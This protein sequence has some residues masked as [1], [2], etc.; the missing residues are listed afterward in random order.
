M[1]VVWCALDTKTG[2]DV[3]IKVMKDISD[4]ASLQLFTKGVESAC[5]TISPEHR[6]CS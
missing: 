1:G 5:G 6:R 3:A 4:S 2:S